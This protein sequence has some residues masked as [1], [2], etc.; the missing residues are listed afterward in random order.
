M[1]RLSCFALTCTV[2][3]AAVL[4]C[5]RC[6]LAER[7][8]TDVAIARELSD[9]RET[10]TISPYGT[11]HASLANGMTVLLR[12]D[13]SAPVAHLRVQVKAGS[14]YEG[15]F[16]GCGI[17][18]LLE[19]LVHGTNTPTRTEEESRELLEQIGNVSNAYTTSDHT[20]YFID[21]SVDDFD[22]ALEL[23][24]DWMLNCDIPEEAFSR[25][26][27]VVVRE[28]ERGNDDPRRML[29]RITWETAYHVS[30]FRIPVIGYRN[31]VE[32]LTYEDVLAYHRRRY[33]PNLMIV[34][35][36]GDFEWQEVLEKVR[37]AFGDAPPGRVPEDTLPQEPPQLTVR[38]VEQE[39]DVN[40]T[41]MNITWQTVPL[42]HEDLYPLDLLSSILSWGESSRFV[43]TIRN[44]K[45]LVHSVYSSSYTPAF[46][47]GVFI[48]GAT[49]EDKN[50]ETAKAA[51][52]EEI[53]E[54][55]KNPVTEAE[56]K[57]AKRQT[58]S[59]HVFGAQTVKAQ[60]SSLASGMSSAND[61]D[62]DEY[63]VE[64]IQKVTAEQI[65]KVAQEYLR[66][67]SYTI[68]AIRPRGSE[69]A[70]P[71]KAKGEAGDIQKFVLD[72]G[73]R[74][75]VRQNTAHPIVAIKAYFP[76]GLRAEND[77]NN[78]ISEFMAN[79][80]TR[81]TEELTAEEIA[82]IF[83]SMGGS[84]GAGGGNN[85]FYVTA[86]ALA[87]DFAKALA[88]FA[89]V[90]RNPSFPEDEIER[91]RQ[92][93]LAGIRRQEKDPDTVRRKLLRE[94]LYTISPYRLNRSG[95]IETI[96][97]LGV[98]GL[99][100]F[101]A[102]CTVPNNMVM[103][104]F[105]DVEPEL[106]LQ[107]VKDAF[108]DFE[109]S[110]DYEAPQPPQE[111]ELDGNRFASK[112][113][114]RENARVA[115]AFPGLKVTDV[116]EQMN[117]MVL[118][119]VMSG[120]SYPTGWIHEE[121]RGKQL[122]YETHG[123]NWVALDRG[124]FAFIATCQP[125]NADMVL[126]IIWKHIDRAKRG[127]ITDEEFE[128]ARQLALAVHALGRQTNGEMAE[129]AAINEMYGLSYDFADKIPEL[130]RQVKK[131]DSI[132]FARDYFNNFVQ[133]VV[134]PSAAEE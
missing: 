77:E 63:Y 106:V 80:L 31:L 60:A 115:I 41:R 59:R 130:I 45:R 110:P 23:L 44:E 98:K 112:K 78:G 54:V 2:F 33:V 17:S 72:N 95:T 48:V 26:H 75:L 97:D 73:M 99:R 53:E 9:V 61:P 1:R 82:A 126:E 28:I 58:L 109:Q 85:T 39:M 104:V 27:G 81:G 111:P 32:N 37:G 22:T 132:E 70:A 90:I 34:S 89:D 129:S 92:L 36:V 3:I 51:I 15:E 18:H 103:S 117:A 83:D 57:R 29:H 122:V 62:F 121:L 40:Q 64:N 134:S 116:K 71:E 42:A 114:D 43:K 20:S 86:S 131:E 119:A 79:M 11:V 120:I 66:N 105:G 12:E 35:A 96:S 101:H 91:I 102:K 124:Y 24:S 13:H 67:D 100:E 50:V 56:L 65:L 5:T 21:C 133:V 94:T 108:A 10:V 16:L 93:T 128:R 6:T 52:L 123:F 46:V 88:V 68:G 19:H 76:G 87:E 30:P 14:I 47:N 113:L 118:Q 69:L 4:S 125:E 7:D 8:E 84:I 74:L 49:L 55:R 38:Q 107:A 25:E 127:E